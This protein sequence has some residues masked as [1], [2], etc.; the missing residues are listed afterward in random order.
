[1]NETLVWV[2]VETTGLDPVNCTILELGLVITDLDL[3]VIAERAWMVDPGEKRWS[4]AKMTP[5]VK[6]M[7]TKNGLLAD[8]RE[9]GTPPWQVATEAVEFMGDH[10][11]VGSPM[12]GSS[13]HFDRAMLAANM[14]PMISAFHYQNIDVSTIKA[15]AGMWADPDMQWV[16]PYEKEHRTL[17]DLRLSI[18][19]L[20]HY[21]HLM[22]WT[23]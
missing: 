7:H 19:E 13:V 18:A 23:L 5:L 3:E 21:R 20:D 6:E 16:A 11:G 12:C 22:G 9:G 4:M 1:M 8:L 17:S 15:I 10:K 2:D 14:P